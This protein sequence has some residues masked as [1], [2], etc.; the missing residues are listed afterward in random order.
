[1]P[2]NI[3]SK[4]SKCV[5]LHMYQGYQYQDKNRA[6]GLV[7]PFWIRFGWVM[8][9]QLLTNFSSDKDAS[10]KSIIALDNCLGN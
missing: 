9:Y 3:G 1:M 5:I 4:D 8:T 10:S 7:K 2:L 6:E